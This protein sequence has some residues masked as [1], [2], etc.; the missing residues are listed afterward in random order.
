MFPI[1]A[2]LLWIAAV[3]IIT[4]TPFRW[5]V[6]FFKHAGPQFY[7]LILLL[8]PVLFI[9]PLVYQRLRL[10]GLWRYELKGRVIEKRIFMSHGQNSVHIQYSLLSGPGPVRLKLRPSVHFRPHQA[11]VEESDTS[12]YAISAVGP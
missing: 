4:A 9:V 1:V 6:E 12:P 11:P 10:R 5:H 7:Q 2:G 3:L 8:L